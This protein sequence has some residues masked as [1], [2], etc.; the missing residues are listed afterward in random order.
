MS[1]ESAD[2]RE[3]F[4]RG[5]QRHVVESSEHVEK[6][7]AS[8]SSSSSDGSN[9]PQPNQP[10]TDQDLNQSATSV[11]QRP[12]VSF[13]P[14][15][16]NPAPFST[17]QSQQAGNLLPNCTLATS[18][19]LYPP[20]R[21]V[22]SLE[23]PLEARVFQPLNSQ[24]DMDISNRNQLSFPSQLVTHGSPC[25][26]DQSLRMSRNTFGSSSNNSY[27]LPISNLPSDFRLESSSSSRSPVPQIHHQ[28]SQI[29]VIIF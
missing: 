15:T 22:E 20:G 19:Q 4:L 18:S 21:L 14:S 27:H 3:K 17:P 12:Q 11:L 5:T 25:P 16:E 1:T 23:T 9:E 8:E 24:Q 6:E 13:E 29:P 26:M 10:N 2:I 7:P 28:H